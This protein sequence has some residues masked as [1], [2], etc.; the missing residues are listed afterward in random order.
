[1]EDRIL[2]YGLQFLFIFA[3]A[4]PEDKGR[5]LS[6]LLPGALVIAAQELGQLL[7]V[8]EDQIGVAIFAWHCVRPQLL[9]E[10]DLVGKLRIGSVSNGPRLLYP[11]G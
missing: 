2:R 8:V 10:E 3:E 4:H 6:R 1:M 7:V 5:K 11:V 9:H